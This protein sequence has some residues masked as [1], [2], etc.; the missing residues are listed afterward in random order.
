MYYGIEDCVIFLVYYNIV[1]IG[2]TNNLKIHDILPSVC[3][4]Y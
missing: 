2:H 4:T 3:D 1:I